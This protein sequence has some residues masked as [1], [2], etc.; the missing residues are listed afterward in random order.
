VSVGAPASTEARTRLAAAARWLTPARVRF[1]LW[2]VALAFGVSAELVAGAGAGAGRLALDLATGWTMIAGGLVVW[3]RRPANPIVVGMVVTGFAW[4]A[5]NFVAALSYVHRGPLSH[6][7]LG[8]PTGRLA[9]ATGVVVGAWY[10]A[11]VVLPLA[12]SDWL[13]IAL[14]GAL[15]AAALARLLRAS[16]RD[17]RDLARAAVAAVAVAAP[18]VVGSVLRVSGTSA[19]FED[20]VLTT[21][22]LAII[23]TAV[24]F[25]GGLLS[26]SE[27]RASAV[28]LELGDAGRAGTVRDALS[29]ALADPSLEVAYWI[30]TSGTYVDE[31]GNA[32]QLSE[33]NDRRGSTVVEDDGVPLAVL[34]HEPGLLDDPGLVQHLSSALRLAMSNARLQAEARAHLE[35]V[36][37]SRQRVF[38]QADAQRHLLERRLL[39]GPE[40]RLA[41]LELTLERARVAARPEAAEVLAEAGDELSRTRAELRELARGLHPVLADNDLAA[42][43]RELATHSPIPVEVRVP[44][45]ELPKAARAT[46]YFL[47]SEALA[48]VTKHADATGAGVEVT[49]A[50]SR[51][52]VVVS[53]DGRGGA[54]PAA[55]SGLRGLAERVEA[56]GGRLRVESPS[57]AGTRVIA[58]IPL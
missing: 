20:P 6:I 10:V 44:P 3:R 47:C 53:D 30:A 56:T 14:S 25:A 9:R 32:L 11:G 39:A 37:A 21:Y 5:G 35:E 22:E 46:V 33:P 48:N 38:D 23:A 2:P 27:A 15:V 54:D 52:R 41:K 49:V 57:G 43:I 26:R 4:F 8:Y 42:A 12:E 16:P 31:R 7:V 34:V 36:R 55:G 13:T 29:R 40:R 45:E 50:G 24:I 28:V 18:L 1:A 17:R 51:A 19:D 58:E